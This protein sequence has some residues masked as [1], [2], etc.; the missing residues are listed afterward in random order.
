MG[1]RRSFDEQYPTR[2]R[3]RRF[4]QRETAFGLAMRGGGN[5]FDYDSEDYR[6]AQIR[7]GLP[8]YSHLD[9]A[10]KDAAALYEGS[11]GDDREMDSG[12]YRWSGLGAAHKPKE[13]PK[14]VGTPEEAATVVA[15]AAGYFG[16]VGVGFCG[17]DR[18]WVYS[19]DSRGRSI[20][21]EDVEEGYT[22]DEKAVIP[23]SHRW[24]IA[25]TV[26]M[27]YEENGYA[28][29]PLDA[30]SNM[31]YSRMH[32]LAGFVAEFIR[33]LGYHAIPMGND[34]ALSVPIA[35]QAGLGHV[36]RHGRL[37]TW[38]RGPL[39]R[40]LKVF[41]DLPLATS[42]PAPGGIVEFCEVCKRCADSCP[43]GSIPKGPRTWEPRCSSNNPSAL[44]WYCDEQACFAH[45]KVVK[46]GCGIC[47]RVCAFTKGPGPHHEAIKWFIRNIPQLNRFW[48]LS[49][50]LLGYGRMRDPMKYWGAN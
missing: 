33:G 18:R 27:E 2:D 29:T 3:Y 47:L 46:S 17:L 26:P 25:L 50:K 44:K 11:P 30:T 41:T 12:Y 34:T 4:D 22:N 6:L 9:Y 32:I 38:E 20:V 39:V 10:F 16:A 48:V 5:P 24:V 8:G 15:K 1:R 7:K 36:G 23:E 42:P 35:A 37:I 14:W 43:S 19:H 31:G 49:D 21:F 40:I 28:P 45:W 13:L